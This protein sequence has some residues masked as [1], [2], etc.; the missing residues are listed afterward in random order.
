MITDVNK[1]F[2]WERDQKLG[3]Q[4]IP[5]EISFPKPPS[6]HCCILEQWDYVVYL[7]RFI[8]ILLRVQK[9]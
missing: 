7:L 3:V 1:L 8:N 9:T 6:E 2:S 5:C 4:P